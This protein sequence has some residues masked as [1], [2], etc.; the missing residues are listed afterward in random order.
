[1]VFLPAAHL[2]NA[3][4]LSWLTPSASL[5]IRIG[6]RPGNT[7]PASSSLHA[8]CRQ[9]HSA[10]V[11][12]TIQVMLQADKAGSRFKVP[13]EVTLTA[14]NVYCQECQQCNVMCTCMRSMHARPWNLSCLLW[15]WMKIR[16]DAHLMNQG[17]HMVCAASRNAAMQCVVWLFVPRSSTSMIHSCWNT[18]SAFESY[19]TNYV[20]MFGSA[21]I[22]RGDLSHS[23]TRNAFV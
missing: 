14:D 16:R 11:I 15:L 20:P 2:S 17:A 5:P 13:P 12:N 6:R 22:L 9:H 1:M 4:R 18:C 10:A 3:F 21:P 7:S 23:R 19:E 8:T